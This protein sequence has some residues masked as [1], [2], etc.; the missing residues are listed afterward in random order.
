MSTIRYILFDAAN[1]LIHKPQLWSQMDTVLSAHGHRVPPELLK[2]NHKLLSE[3][4]HFP[5]RTSGDFYRRFNAELLYSLGIIPSEKLLDDLFSR[6]TY[7]PWEKFPDTEILLSLNVPLGVL[8]NFNSTLLE[9]LENKFGRI[10][11]DVLISE[12]VGYGKPDP[13]FFQRAVEMS[14]VP[15]GQILYVGDSLKLDVQPA[16]A[17]GM[18]PL[19]I[20][21]E[22]IFPL[23]AGRMTSLEQ[24]TVYL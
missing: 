2:R 5:D 14:G 17:A 11:R 7:L 18:K 1:T 21:R 13:R 3:S 22:N 4:V 19:L 6:C 24:L 12:N 10:F 23:A 15:A 16:M 9:L 8:S 20:D